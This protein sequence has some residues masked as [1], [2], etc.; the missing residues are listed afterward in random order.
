MACVPGA[1]YS[2][3]A[4]ATDTIHFNI[5][6]PLIVCRAAAK[7]QGAPPAARDVFRLASEVM[8]DAY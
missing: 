3:A 8:V 1:T 4:A 5:P 7:S 2:V 6:V